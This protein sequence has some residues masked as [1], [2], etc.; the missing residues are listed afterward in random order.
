MLLAAG[1][2]LGP[3]EI[4]SP[5]GAGGMGEVYRARDTRLSREVAIKVLPAE[6]SSDAER[7]KRFEKE[8]QSASSL[9]HPNI[10]TIYDI[11]SEGGVSYIAMEKVEGTTLR[12][13][14]VSG[15]MATKKLLQIAPQMAEGLARAHEAGIVHRDL[16]PENV[17]V[18]K[19][20]LVKILDFGLA[21]LMTARPEGHD[22]RDLSTETGTSPGMVLGTVGYM[23]PEQATG[24]GIDFRSDQFSLGSILYEMATGRRAF[25][26]ETRVDT[27]SAI[28]HE[29]PEP[30]ASLN[31]QAPVLLHWVVERCLA[32]EPGAR[33][34]ATGDLARDLA[35]IRDHLS[36]V[37]VAIGPSKARPDPRRRWIRAAIAVALL[38]VLAVGVEVGRRA[39]KRTPPVFKR[40]TF[41]R[42]IVATARFLGD[43]ETIVYGAAWNGEPWRIFSTRREGA[44]ST[45]LSLPPGFLQAVSP[46]GE[47]AVTLVENTRPWAVATGGTLARVPLAGGA[48]REVLNNVQLADWGPDSSL[49][50]V[51]SAGPKVRLEYPLGTT[52]YETTGDIRGVRV[53]P[54]GELVAILDNPNR[55]DDGGSVAVVDR[56]GNKRTL[57]SGFSSMSGLAWSRDG[58]ELWFAAAGDGIANALHTV[59]LSG[60]ERILL[61]TPAPMSV[62]DVAADGSVLIEEHSTGMRIAGLAPR[63]TRERDLSWL[64]YSFACDL[65]PDGKS[66]AFEESGDGAGGSYRLY[67][68]RTD[69]SPP[70]RLFDGTCGSLSAD[71]QW[72]L[73]RRFAPKPQDVL[74]PVR[75][76]NIRPLASDP[77]SVAGLGFLP[78]G[79]RIVIAGREAGHGIRLYVEDLS[80]GHPRPITPEGVGAVRAAKPISPDGRWVFANG[81]DGRLTMYAVESGEERPVPGVK[82]ADRPLQWA[83]DGRAI[84]VMERNDAV[85]RIVSVD[86][87]TGRRDPWKEIVPADPAGFWGITSFF[88]AEDGRSYVYSYQRTLSDL[89]MISGLE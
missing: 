78:D 2:R 72:V 14:L 79:E 38:G 85:F 37:V 15:A 32:K 48:P 70:T 31:P 81:P 87:A 20:G 89:Y 45:L 88:I 9:N 73:S 40:L 30:I 7:L 44:E 67:L 26:R 54:R 17:M 53:S 77:P 8:A 86:V 12:G 75:S 59:S 71:G 84:F 52:L 57:A 61:R 39:E 25:R 68:G 82:P 62:L 63:E 33:Y 16:K 19:D 4:L 49:A 43:G 60:R 1:A 47:L 18:T 74:V 50:A 83:P 36:E 21:K 24:E 58:R 27:L 22:D 64:D 13:L 42:G 80:E 11:G 35:T 56:A 6:L 41:R 46:S 29:E 65:S 5:L 69:G 66:F 51:R 28:V 76:G 3:Y 55:G 10:V 34:G 23:S